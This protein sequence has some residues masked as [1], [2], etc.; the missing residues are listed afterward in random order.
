MALCALHFRM[1]I[2]DRS[3]V[4][5]TKRE[6]TA[7]GVEYRQLVC[8]LQESDFVSVNA[9]PALDVYYGALRVGSHAA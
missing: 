5:W 6:K 7:L 3:V 1:R 9:A 2:L 8:N 4:D